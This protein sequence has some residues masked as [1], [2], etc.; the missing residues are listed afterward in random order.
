MS[1]GAEDARLAAFFGAESDHDAEIA[2]TAIFDQPT[3]RALTE[4]VRR[5]LIG[6]APRQSAAEDI[7]SDTRVRL[8][9]RLWAV[10]RDGGDPIE[11]FTAYA[12]TTAT[13]TCYAYLRARFPA[14]TRFR[15]QVRYTVMRHPDTSLDA[16]G[17]GIW[18][19]RSRALRLAT[20]QAAAARSGQQF[21]DAPRELDRLVDALALVLAIGDAKPVA[22]AAEAEERA[23]ERVPDPAPDALRELSDRAELQALWFEVAAL[24]TNQRIALLLNLRDPDGGSALHAMP[25]TGIVTRAELAQLLELDDRQ[26]DQ[27]WD[28][29]PLDDLTIASQL[30]LTR[31]QVI[32]LRKSARAR[33]LRRTE[34]R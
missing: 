9:R 10:R 11:D 26:L 3:E 29:L 15:N 14:R 17:D 4:A 6:S 13:R 16:D 27:V 12:A 28:E 25:S 5:R 18:R 21:V 1:S 34:R 20:A 19:C 8:I 31:Q 23:V 33:L 22:D 30:G 7:A 24:P 2:L 32:N